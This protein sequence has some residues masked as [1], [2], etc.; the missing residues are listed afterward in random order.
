MTPGTRACQALLSSTASWSCVKFVLV[1]LVTLSSPSPPAFMLSQ[2]QGLFQGVFSS[3]EMAKVL[4]PQLQDL[5]FQRALRADFLQNGEVSCPCSPGDSQ[6]PPP[7]SQFKGINS[8]A[9][10]F[11]YGPALTSI[12]H[13]RKNHSFDYS[14]LCR[15]EMTK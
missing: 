8:S 14:D 7:A 15:L 1:A 13:Y 3:L 2:H 11:L 12:H 9:V 10:S 5:S 6:E 4:E